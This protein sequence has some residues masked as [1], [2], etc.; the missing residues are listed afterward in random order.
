MLV[1]LD[2]NVL[3]SVLLLLAEGS[4]PAQLIVH[5]R[6]GRFDLLTAAGRLINELRSL[7]VVVEMLPPVAA[8]AGPYDNYL[9]SIAAGGQADFFVTGDKADLLALGTH[10]GTKIVSVRDFITL[11]RLPS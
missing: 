5:W 9:P 1:V 6:Q 10:A 4:P 8:S 7:A 11:S 3:I 2:T